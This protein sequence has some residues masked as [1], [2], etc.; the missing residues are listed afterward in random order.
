MK[1]KTIYKLILSASILLL[2]DFSFAQNTNFDRVLN[3][4]DSESIDNVLLELQKIDTST[5]SIYDKATWLFY[6]ADYQSYRDKHSLAYRNAIQSKKLFKSLNKDSDVADC[7]ILLLSIL[8]H[9]NNLDINS[10][11]IINELE[12]YAL[13][14]NDT[15][16]LISVYHQLASNYLNNDIGDK[17]LSYFKKIVELQKLRQDTLKIAQYQMNIGT[18]YYAV[19]NNPDSSLYYTKKAVPVLKKYEDFQTLAY[20]YNNQAQQYKDIGDYNQAIAYYLKADSIPLEKFEAKSKIIFYENMSEAFRLNE[21]YKNA[22]LYLNKL[23]RLKDSINDTKQNIAI[24]EIKEQYDNEKLRAD[25]LVIEAKNKQTRNLLI[26]AL[27]LLLFGGITA[28]LIQKNTRKKQKLAEQEK[29]LEAQKLATVLK[30]QEL[31]AIDAMIEGQEKERQRIANDLHDDLGGLMATVKLHF[32]ALKDKN[33]PELFDK[34]NSLIE[35]AYQKVRSVAHAKNSGVIA[36]QGLLKAVEQ[37]AEKVS[38]TSQL[39]ISVFD[40]GLDDR[41]ENSLELTIFRIIQEL[42]T[43]VI[44]HANASEINIHITN[45]QDTLNIMVEDDGIGFN[46]NQIT[47]TKKGMGIS[48]IDKRVEHLNGKMTIE[49]ERHKGTTIII[50]IPI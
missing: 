2:A 12:T 8:S 21:D 27:A 5:I 10:D 50:D 40:H 23:I 30:E 20:N 32:N 42:I 29:A 31:T 15:S 41:L 9:Q 28:F 49:S 1:I 39:N 48:S 19:L 37:M 22:T 36:K 14:D 4:Y 3:A 26:A 33:S 35:E 7:N 6:M 38:V 25:N 46:P 43:N 11:T 17:S 18:V 44:K 13:K 45:H 24:S 47:K 34:T 16:A